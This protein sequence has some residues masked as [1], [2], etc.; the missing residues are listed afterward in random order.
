MKAEFRKKLSGVVQQVM[1]IAF[2]VYLIRPD[3]TKANHCPETIKLYAC[4]VKS[5]VNY[6]ILSYHPIR[7]GFFLIVFLCCCVAS[8][9]HNSDLS[10]DGASLL[11]ELKICH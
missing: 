7:F 8:A 10:Q 9:C 6:V 1:L 4:K 5:F 3:G 2:C 11:A